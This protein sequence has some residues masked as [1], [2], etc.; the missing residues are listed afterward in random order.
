MNPGWRATAP[1][2]AV[3]AGEYAVLDGATAVVAALDRR[4]SAVLRPLAGGPCRVRAP[5]LSDDERSFAVTPA[6]IEWQDGLP[7]WP[8]LEHCW[9]ES[10]AAIDGPFELELDTRPFSDR[11]TGRKLGIGSS[12]A[13][14]SALSCVLCAASGRDYGIGIAMRAHSAFQ[15]GRGSGVDVAASNAGGVIAFAAGRFE[16]LAWPAGL[17]ALFL[18]SGRP[19]D[20]RS[21]LERVADA[22]NRASRQDLASAAGAAAAAWQSGDAGAVLDG[23]AAW[24]D[25]LGR[26][27]IDHDLGV[28]DAG[29]AALVDAAAGESLV[30]KPCGAGGGDIGVVLGTDRAA[31]DAFGAAAAAHG[32]TATDLAIEPLGLGMHSD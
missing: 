12:A 14:A 17:E 21:R 22:D 8:M 13:L 7:P 10:R 4:A 29:H 28:F 18:W 32:F 1:G 20:T 3:L 23:V 25:A 24:V 5:G 19:A 9:R 31:L 30:Y 11:R 6:G 27:S 16:R 26:F 15:G 2:K